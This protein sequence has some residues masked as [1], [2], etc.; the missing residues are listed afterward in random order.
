M[1]GVGAVVPPSHPQPPQIIEMIHNTE[2][3]K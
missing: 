1:G 2:V 3:Y